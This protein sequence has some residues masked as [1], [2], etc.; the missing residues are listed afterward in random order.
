M[1]AKHCLSQHHCPSPWTMTMGTSSWNR[2]AEDRNRCCNGS[3][4]VHVDHDWKCR[5]RFASLW[6]LLR[7]Y[8]LFFWNLCLVLSYFYQENSIC[9]WKMMYL[10][11]KKC[12]GPCVGPDRAGPLLGTFGRAGWGW[13][14]PVEKQNVPTRKSN[15]RHRT[16]RCSGCGKSGPVYGNSCIVMDNSVSLWKT[17]YPSWKIRYHSKIRNTLWKQ[18]PYIYIYTL[19]I[20]VL[21]AGPGWSFTWIF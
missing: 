5:A 19:Y 17:W 9:W 12:A 21:T 7:S 1:D 20:Y 15:R 3:P 18:Q 11:S 4:C 6:N 14:G 16:P 8:Y 10:I 13:T 2:H